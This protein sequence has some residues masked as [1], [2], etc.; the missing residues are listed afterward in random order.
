VIIL[1]EI[2]SLTSESILSEEVICEVLEEQDE[3]FKAKLLLTL[4]DKSKDL[5]VKTKFEK[6][7]AAYKKEKAKFDKGQNNKSLNQVE[8][9]AMTHF[10]GN[11]PQMNCGMWVANENGVTS[12]RLSYKVTKLHGK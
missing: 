3:V 4:I 11:Y 6:L 2:N 8:H 10:E 12:I 9:D 5:G 7:V 1:Q